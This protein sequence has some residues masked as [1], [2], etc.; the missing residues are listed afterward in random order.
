[1]SGQAENF[2]QEVTSFERRVHEMLTK[3]QLQTTL[4]KLEDFHPRSA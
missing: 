1:M 3:T 4:D 2:L